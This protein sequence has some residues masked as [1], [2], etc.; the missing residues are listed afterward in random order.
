MQFALIGTCARAATLPLRAILSRSPG[1]RVAPKYSVSPQTNCVDS[2]AAQVSEA[3]RRRDT[4]AHAQQ[5][6][7]LFCK[8]GETMIKKHARL[9]AAVRTALFAGS[10][11]MLLMANSATGQEADEA[12]IF[13]EIVT[14]G[15]RVVDPNLEQASQVLV[16]TESEISDRHALDAESLVGELPGIAPGTNRSLN[17][18]TNGTAT[19]NL[20]G[21]GDN[22]NL[23]LLD[24]QRL[25]P[26]DLSA[27]TDLNNIP[28]ALVERVDIV[29]GGASSVYGADAV[30]GVSNFVL[31]R[32]FEGVQ[33]A[34]TTSATG[35]NDGETTRVDLTLGG[36]FVGG[37]GNAAINIGYQEIEGVEQGQREYSQVARFGTLP[38]GSPTSVPT[39]INSVQYNPDTGMSQPGDTFNFAPFNYFQT[40]LERYNIFAKAHYNV[41]DNAEVYVN[42]LYARNEVDLQIAPSGMFGDTWFMPLNNPFLPDFFR[43]SICAGQLTPIDQATC[44]AAGSAVNSQ[45]PNYLEVPVVV[46]RRLVEMG[47][48]RTTFATDAFQFT[49][50]TR[51]D[52][53]DNLHFDIY[54]QYGESARTTTRRNW[55]LKS[56]LQQSLRAT[57]A[58]TCDPSTNP[59]AGCV[60]VNLFGGGDGQNISQGVVD[61]INR[62]SGLTEKTSLTAAV[63]SL[64]GTIDAPDFLPTDLPLGFAAGVEYREYTASQDSDIA[65][66]TQDEVMGTGA[67]SP[68]FSGRYNVNEFFVESIVPL[69]SG[70]TGIQ[71][72]TLEAGAR[73]SDYSTSG[74]STTWKAGGTWEPTDGLKIRGIFQE[75]ARSPNIFELFNPPTTGLNN[76]TF[77]PCQGFL[78][79]GVTPNP[80]LS[81]PDIQAICIAQGAPA[82]TVTG[83]LIP[84]PAANQINETQG[85]NTALDVETAESVTFGFIFTP[86]SLPNLTLSVDYYNITIE[87]AIAAPNAGDIFDPCFGPGTPGDSFDQ[88]DPTSPSC[89]FI[90]RNP[91]NGSLNGGGDTLGLITQVTNQGTL[92]SSGIDFRILYDMDVD[93]GVIETMSFDMVGN[94]TDKLLFQASPISVNRECVGQFSENCDPSLPETT[95]NLR[96]T[97]SMGDWGDVSLLWRWQDELVYERILD[98]PF[99]GSGL[100]GLNDTEF[101][102]MDSASYFDLLYTRDIGELISI[103]LLVVNVTDE[104]PPITG[105]FLGV[106]GYNSGNTY[107][108]NYD[109]LGR[110]WSL[111][112]TLR[113]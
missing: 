103:S 14:T 63:A 44:D 75:S 108:S 62:P 90:G 57:D 27:R 76:Q 107:P 2:E 79:D 23:I 110:R 6:L 106:T 78:A 17:N 61:F 96:T 99:E 34:M 13:D 72:L 91:L 8:Q 65:A 39:S 20:R 30:A 21:L 1:K 22:R 112:G 50:G 100:G 58:D 104:Q 32:D 36:N 48:R 71:S 68:I 43:N 16:M 84:A 80:A 54:G 97:A 111:T 98:N 113:F 64:S 85:G 4:R 89:A 83:G 82:G 86:E 24:G 45:D 55:G 31:K 40:P 5:L 56:L 15:S 52:L 37:R 67:P 88:A 66:A 77:D 93:W 49:I 9:S 25:V 42:G 94:F 60:P 46:N 59:S 81:N 3:L 33:L 41:S 7:Q 73:F 74:S 28:M 38:L 26:S 11:A 70:R 69:V 29:T 105:N 101:L 92:E 19:L 18:G 53:T 12:E 109:T 87:D 51:A 95:F 10:S 102:S 47:P 35:E